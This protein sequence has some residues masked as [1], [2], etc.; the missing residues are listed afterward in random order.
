MKLK[1]AVPIRYQF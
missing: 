1:T